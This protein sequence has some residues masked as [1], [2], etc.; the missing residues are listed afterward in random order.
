MPVKE[1]VVR[2]ESI[3]VLLKALPPDLTR[4]ITAYVGCIAG[5][6]LLTDYLRA[7]LDAGL[8]DLSIPRMAY[9]PDLVKALAP[10]GFDGSKASCCGSTVSLKSLKNPDAIV[11]EASQALTM[12]S[13][14][15]HG[16][17]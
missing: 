2:T 15:L 12:A 8:R 7:V 6:S 1:A 14:K 3:Q 10:E 9:G 17:K 5:A 13:I 16:T 4:N 11:H